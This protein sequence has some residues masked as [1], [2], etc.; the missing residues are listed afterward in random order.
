MSRTIRQ[1]SLCGSPVTLSGYGLRDCAQPQSLTHIGYI[2]AAVLIRQPLILQRGQKKKKSSPYADKGIITKNDTDDWEDK[3][4]FI[5]FL[6]KANKHLDKRSRIYYN[7]LVGI[8][9]D[10]TS[11]RTVGRFVFDLQF[12]NISRCGSV[13]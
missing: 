8:S 6:K 12:N 3:A 1:C 13:W 10:C 4:D 5:A 9:I 2:K 11:A 7:F